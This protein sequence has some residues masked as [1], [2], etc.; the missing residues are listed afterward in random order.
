MRFASLHAIA[1]AN[2]SAPSRRLSDLGKLLYKMLTL[3]ASD[4]LDAETALA[5]LRAI[6]ALA[7][8]CG[9]TTT[10]YS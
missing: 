2:V 1:S 6:C 8:N 3:H 4:R 7:A 10:Y 9:P 5:D